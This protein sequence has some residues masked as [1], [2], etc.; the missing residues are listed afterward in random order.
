[1][2]THISQAPADELVEIS[3]RGLARQLVL[4]NL[5]RDGISRPEDWIESVVDQSWVY[6]R[7]NATVALSALEAAGYAVVPL[8]PTEEMREAALKDEASEAVD[9]A[10]VTAYV[11]GYRN[12][13]RFKADNAPIL[14]WYRAMLAARPR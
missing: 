5:R 1:V 10:I 9:G 13:D 14:R 12:V 2:S 11:H 4:D 6:H 8:E 7:N 3:A